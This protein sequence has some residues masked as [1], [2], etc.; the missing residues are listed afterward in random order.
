MK[1]RSVGIFLQ[2][3]NT[4]LNMFCSLFLSAFL[5][6]ELGDTEYGL[7]QTIS[8]FISN[9]ILLEF[10]TGTVITRNLVAA[11]T[12]NDHEL[13]QKNVSTI[14]SMTSILVGLIV[15][16]GGIFYCSI[17]AIYSST[18]SQTQIQYGKKIFLVMLGVL[19]ASFYTN[20]LNGVLLGYEQYAI[21]PV[22]A[23]LRL[24]L[25]T[26]LLVFLVLKTHLSIAIAIVDLFLSLSVDIF[27]IVYC[28]R[29]F[30]IHFRFHEFDHQIFIRSLPLASALFIQT[31][32]NQANN[33]VDKFVIGIKLGPETVAVYSIGLYVYSL[34]SSL[35]TIPISMYSPQ[36]VRE[37][38]N[39]YTPSDVS[40][41]LIQPSRYIVLIGGSILF[42]FFAVGR[43][44]ITI[45]Y[46][47][48]YVIAWKVAIIIMI[49]MLINMSN[50]IMINILDAIDKRIVRSNVLL[51]TTIAN[52]IL[53][54]WWIDKYGI[55]GACIAT[56]VCTLLGQVLL[57]DLYYTKR[58]SI[59]MVL[60]RIKTFRGII[61]WQLAASIIAFILG[62]HISNTIVSFFV[63]GVIFVIVFFVLFLSL[64]ASDDEKKILRKIMDKLKTK[65]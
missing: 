4:F 59:N 26:M 41:H 36:V 29:R 34:F 63:G 5:L 15:I 12:S 50:G 23:I 21:Q 28:T 54:V 2:Y 30:G 13:Q 55:I 27:L 42:G 46:G 56:A 57:M 62:N 49:P 58:L 43:Q 37:I 52:I 48:S 64:G 19:V 8:S 38:S 61:V 11:R 31:L 24:L 10:G 39:G 53:T 51:V 6:R 16:V 32:V 33:N 60:F 47:A 17:G 65:T 18:L 44:F 14:W 45:V 1:K 22:I 3:L 25:R 7:Y 35:T 40:M 9:L 20:T